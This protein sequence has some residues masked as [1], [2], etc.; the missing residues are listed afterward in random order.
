MKQKMAA[1]KTN[2]HMSVEQ[3]RSLIIKPYITEKTFNMIERENT[4]TFIVAERATKNQ[5]KEALAMLYES[6]VIEVNTSRTSQGKK[7]HMK[8][9]ELE[10]ARNLATTLG[11]V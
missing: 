7:A 6:Q 9:K 1:K 10:G 11:L 2:A 4:L 3:A 5:I 8:F